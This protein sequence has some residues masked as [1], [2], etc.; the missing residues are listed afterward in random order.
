MG[1][2]AR[3]F[4]MWLSIYVIRWMKERIASTRMSHYTDATVFLAIHKISLSPYT[5]PNC[6]SWYSRQLFLSH[7]ANRISPSVRLFVLLSIFFCGYNNATWYR[8]HIDHETVVSVRNE[9][10][11]KHLYSTQLSH[12]E[13]QAFPMSCFYSDD[14]RHYH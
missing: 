14:N 8:Q 11:E 5:S 9:L 4:I 2:L 7:K 12:V 6:S 10:I 13:A 3:L 1:R